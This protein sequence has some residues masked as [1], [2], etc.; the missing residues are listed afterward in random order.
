MKKDP[1]EAFEWLITEFRRYTRNE[2]TW[3]QVREILREAEALRDQWRE[4]A[5]QEP[6]D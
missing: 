6:V 3:V 5:N 1:I 4:Q 2:I